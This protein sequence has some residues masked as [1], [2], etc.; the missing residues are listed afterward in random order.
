MGWLRLDGLNHQPD[1]IK[2]LNKKDDFKKGETLK[3]FVLE[4]FKNKKWSTDD[5]FIWL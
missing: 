5:L 1:K 4:C 2:L 3:I